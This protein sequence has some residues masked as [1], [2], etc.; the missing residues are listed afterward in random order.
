MKK[1]TT[2][3][4]KPKIPKAKAPKAP[5]LSNPG[6]NLGKYLHPKKGY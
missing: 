2:H 3:I 5:K 4:S 6:K 1:I